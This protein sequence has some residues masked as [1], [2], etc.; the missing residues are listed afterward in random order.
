VEGQEETQNA[1]SLE[2][3]NLQKLVLAQN[4]SNFNW[5]DKFA[6]ALLNGKKLAVNRPLPDVSI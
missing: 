5:A 3:K 2:S 4:T 6:A 1:T